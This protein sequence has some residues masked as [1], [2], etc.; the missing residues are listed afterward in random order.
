MFQPVSRPIKET[1]VLAGRDARRFER[2]L[3][4][5][6]KRDHRTDFERAKKVYE[7]VTMGECKGKCNNP[8]RA[9]KCDA[10]VRAGRIQLLIN[11]TDPGYF[12]FVSVLD[13]MK[14]Q[15]VKAWFGDV[16]NLDGK[17]RCGLILTSAGLTQ[18]EGQR[19][20]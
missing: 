2:E 12:D 9:F 8:N 7:E 10:V 15:G 4:A 6:A 16:A 20:C 19:K 5:N 18:S 11:D 13:A 1:P 3:A 14:K 17:G